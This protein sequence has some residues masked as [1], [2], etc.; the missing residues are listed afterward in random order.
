VGNIAR[1][2]RGGETRLLKR[3]DL[4]FF[5]GFR[6]AQPGGDQS[7]RLDEWPL[8]DAAQ[9]IGL[10]RFERDEAAE[11]VQQ[12]EQVAGI[13]AL[14]S[15]HTYGLMANGATAAAFGAWMVRQCE[16]RGPATVGLWRTLRGALDVQSERCV[17]QKS[18]T[19]SATKVAP[20]FGWFHARLYPRDRQHN[21]EWRQA[22][23]FAL[24]R[25]SRQEFPRPWEAR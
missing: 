1:Q 22:N 17:P 14:S 25:V 18:F 15:K 24:A 10:R 21:G 3:S 12:I 19:A 9:Q 13:P 8:A 2:A 11:D 6:L 20:Q 4:V 16:G 23:F 5:S 7:R